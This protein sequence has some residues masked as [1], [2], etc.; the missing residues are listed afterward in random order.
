MKV[1]ANK[2]NCFFVCIETPEKAAQFHEVHVHCMRD[3]DLKQGCSSRN[4]I[5][6]SNFWCCIH[7]ASN[8]QPFLNVIHEL[9]TLS[10][11]SSDKCFWLNLASKARFKRRSSH[12]PNLMFELICIRFDAWEERRLNYSRPNFCWEVPFLPQQNPF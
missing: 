12:A 4:M 5:H 3:E 2:F 1:S 10:Y 6:V 11:C 7:I 9:R 8:L